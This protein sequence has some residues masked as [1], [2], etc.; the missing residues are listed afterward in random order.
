MKKIF[1]VLTLFATVFAV[2]PSSAYAFGSQRLVVDTTAAMN[3]IDRKINDLNVKPKERINYLEDKILGLEKQLKDN[4]QELAYLNEIHHNLS[5]LVPKIK[6]AE[7]RDQLVQFLESSFQQIPQDSIFA[8]SKP[9]DLQKA[10]NSKDRIAELQ[11]LKEKTTE[12]IIKSAKKG[13]FSSGYVIGCLNYFLNKANNNK[14]ILNS[15]LTKAKSELE[16]EQTRIIAKPAFFTAAL[17]LELMGENTDVPTK[18]ITDTRFD[19]DPELQSLDDLIKK[20]YAPVMGR[21]DFFMDYKDWYSASGQRNEW[22]ET[23]LILEGKFDGLIKDRLFLFPA[24][25]RVQNYIQNKNG[26]RDSWGG[27]IPVYDKVLVISENGTVPPFEYSLG[28]QACNRPFSF[29]TVN[30]YWDES[31]KKRDGVSILTT[32]PE[33]SDGIKLMMYNDGNTWKTVLPDDAEFLSYDE[34]ID[35]ITKQGH[36][37]QI[38]K[39]TEFE[40]VIFSFLVVT[41]KM[42]GHTDK[43]NPDSTVILKYKNSDDTSERSEGYCQID[44]PGFS[45]IYTDKFSG[46]EY[47]GQVIVAEGTD[48]NGK[49]KK[50]IYRPYIE[51]IPEGFTLNGREISFSQL[52]DQVAEGTFNN[53]TGK[54]EIEEIEPDPYGDV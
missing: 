21:K 23:P 26:E 7:V 14:K 34:A 9:K 4:G 13:D 12:K 18:K 45:K 32:Y 28:F 1:Y 43:N 15:D 40:P 48:R 39:L 42:I 51:E 46:R 49:K 30:T 47:S 6:N 29:K 3:I 44:I 17:W 25:L 27:D 16:S 11:K 35:R 22:E 52:I 38:L 8:Y 19:S 5:P 41:N 2:A 33:S 20:Y 36:T 54:W 53:N 31:G 50:Y 37:P 10:Q 24:N